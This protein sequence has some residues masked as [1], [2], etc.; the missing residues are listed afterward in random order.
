MADF[1]VVSLPDT[2]H[3]D[4]GETAPDF[5]RP[6]VNGEYWENV[7]LSDLTAED[8][9]LLAFHPMD[10]AFLT[11]Y[12]WQELKA[13]DWSETARVVG[14]S[15]SDPYT[16]KQLLRDRGLVD[17]PYALFSDPGNAVA[18]AYGIVN[19]LDGMDGIEEPRP[20]IFL[21]DRDREVRSAWVAREWPD[22]PPYDDI[23]RAID[24]L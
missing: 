17:E 6:L 18:E 12:L 23:E 14:L 16:H 3:V 7:A 1:A 13:R 22:Y 5:T 24:R 10:K 15:I 4:V 19:R 11:T 8:P 20:A 21:L 9:V 2:D